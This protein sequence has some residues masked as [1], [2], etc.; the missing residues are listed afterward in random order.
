MR[1]IFIA[2]LSGL[3]I[4]AGTASAQTTDDVLNLLTKKGT[5]SQQEADSIRLAYAAKQRVSEAR[6]DSFPLSLGR[7]LR[8]SGY[9]QVRYQY[10]QQQSKYDEFDI[11][12]AR[13]DF[14]GDFSSKWGYRLLV[15]FVGATGATGTAPTGGA[16]IS[17]ILLDAF[18]AYKPFDF[19]KITAGQF[20]IPFS[21]ENLTQDRNLET[22]DRS[23]VVNALVARKGDASNGLVDSIGNQNGRD[24]GLQISGSFIRVED[25]YLVDY[26]LALLN[27]AGI[28]TLDNNQSKDFDGRLVLHPFKILDIGASYYNGFDKFTS[29]PTK[30][31]ERIRWGAEMA[32]NFKLLSIKSEYI[33]GQEGNIN[34]IQHEGWYAQ[35]SYFLWPK[36]LQAVFRYDTYD[37]NTIQGKGNQTSTYYVF[38][39]NYFFNVWTKLQ[40]NYSRRTETANTN[41]DVFTAQLQLAF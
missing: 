16:L 18:I 1:S 7:M 12:R 41:N 4:M 29:S 19:L 36:H 9:T 31:Q 20:T 34:P 35:A 5:I 30:N 15:D 25:R 10:Y 11:R 14:Q 21:L 3:L 2:L 17:P 13:L 28:N 22:V 32:L 6:L 40:V 23:Q 24:L 8:L 38:G 33:R 37:P 39:L 27:G 26:Y